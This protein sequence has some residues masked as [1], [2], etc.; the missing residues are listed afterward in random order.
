MVSLEKGMEGEVETDRERQRDGGESE[1][2]Q[3]HLPWSDWT[4]WPRL[5]GTMLTSKTLSTRKNV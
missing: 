3:M 1:R 4:L 5:M 2:G